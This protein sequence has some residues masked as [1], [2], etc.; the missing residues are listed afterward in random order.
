MLYLDVCD[1]LDNEL[2]LFDTWLLLLEDELFPLKWDNYPFIKFI[3][4]DSILLLLL[5][6]ELFE[7][8]LLFKPLLLILLLSLLWLLLILLIFILLSFMPCY[9]LLTDPLDNTCSYLIFFLIDFSCCYNISL[10]LGLYLWYL[11]NFDFSIRY[12]VCIYF[13]IFYLLLSYKINF[14]C[15]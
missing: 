10:T 12:C 15:I 4:F 8:L 1:V 7:L 2:L 14:F 11:S 9:W 5:L 3:V 13:I 6:F